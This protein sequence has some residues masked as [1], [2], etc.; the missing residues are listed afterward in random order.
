MGGLALRQQSFHQI[1]R[2]ART[3]GAKKWLGSKRPMVASDATF[4]RVLPLMNRSQLR[5]FVDQA[6]RLL[7]HRGHGTLVLPS[8]R[9]LRA[10]AVDGTTWGGRYVSAVEILGKP[11]VV[12]DFEPAPGKGHELAASQ[13]VLRRCVTSLGKGFVDIVLGDGLYI[14]QGMLRLCPEDLG[15]HL[16]VKTKELDSLNLLKD[17]EAIFEAAGEFGP[18]VEH[19]QGIDLVRGL[20][21]EIWAAT[22]FRHEGYERELKVARVVTEP[23][24]GQGERETF[25]IITT[26]LT[27][28][29]EDMR[30]LA[31]LRWSIE[32][33]GFRALNEAMNSKHVWTRGARAAEVFEAL[34]LMMLLS[35]M[36]VVAFE[37]ELDEEKLFQKC[38]V[39]RLT[40]KQLTE[41]WLMSIN[42]AE[43]LFALTG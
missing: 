15:T 19:R 41:Y 22:G 5:Q 42:E 14:T 10:A 21:Y 26:D 11:S 3:E 23:I 36:L 13:A 20:S 2:F 35:F 27:L 37:A 33:H 8:G 31:H 40:L 16:L 32:N 38:R 6:Y 24:K 1:D 30:E 12:I 25:W 28:C 9:K 7:R 4:W 39:R 43:G 18:E 29:A 34:M 17:A